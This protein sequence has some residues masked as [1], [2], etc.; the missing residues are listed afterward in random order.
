MREEGKLRINL[1][2]APISI[3][4]RSGRYYLEYLSKEA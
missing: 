4:R 3:S 1:A 2:S